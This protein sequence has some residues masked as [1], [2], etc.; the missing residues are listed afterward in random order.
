MNRPSRVRPQYW[1]E[2]KK[3]KV[4]GRRLPRRCRERVANRPNSTNRVLSKRG[5]RPKPA[6]RA[7]RACH[8]K[9]RWYRSRLYVGESNAKWRIVDGQ[10]FEL[11]PPRQRKVKCSAV[12]INEVILAPGNG[13]FFSGD[14]AAIRTGATQEGFIYVGELLTSIRV[15]ASSLSVGLLAGATVVGGDLMGARWADPN[16]D[17]SAVQYC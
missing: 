17:V 3:A 13:P 11:H 7:L 2:P 10:C 12:Q 15:P 6:S 16:Y 1:A 9:T 8:L 4:S 14:Q 5:G